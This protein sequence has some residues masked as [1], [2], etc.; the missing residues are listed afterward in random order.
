MKKIFKPLIG[1]F[2][3]AISFGA[4]AASEGSDKLSEKL[5]NDINQNLVNIQLQNSQLLQRQNVT[6]KDISQIDT[7]KF[8]LHASA[9]YSLGDVINVDGIKLRCRFSSDGLSAFDGGAKW[10]KI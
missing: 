10:V 5:L 1:I 8:C 6:I 2:F 3:T 4:I 7:K 9:L